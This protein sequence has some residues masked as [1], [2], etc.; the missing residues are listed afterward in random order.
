MEPLPAPRLYAA[1]DLVSTESSQRRDPVGGRPC[2]RTRRCIGNTVRPTW[3]DDLDA[4]KQRPARR[5]AH[6]TESAAPWLSTPEGTAHPAA[7][8]RIRRSKGRLASEGR[9]AARH[10]GNRRPARRWR[11]R[12]QSHR[13]GPSSHRSANASPAGVS[14]CRTNTSRA[15]LRPTPA[16]ESP[17]RRPRRRWRESRD[18]PDRA[19]EGD[20]AVAE[21]R[22]VHGHAIPAG[23]VV[24][25][26][27]VGAGRS[28]V[29]HDGD[30]RQLWPPRTRGSRR[31]RR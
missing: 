27:D 19:R 18:G 12:P 7:G 25:A 29:R 3:L 17:I 30:G 28:F 4:R 26:H 16:S 10:A 23:N 8:R 15:G 31:S 5:P 21:R 20:P 22:Q 1:C 13:G 2:T 6:L 24:A 9:A 11:A 14:S